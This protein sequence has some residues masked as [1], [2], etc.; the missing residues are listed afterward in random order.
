MFE[1]L[2]ASPV[3]RSGRPFAFAL[4]LHSL[5]VVTA[6]ELRPAT[7]PPARVARL[8]PAWIEPTSTREPS[9][10]SG[11]PRAGASDR[12]MLPPMPSVNVDIGPVGRLEVPG[13]LLS[14]WHPDVPGTDGSVDIVAG[15]LGDAVR[16]L[17]ER[18]VPPELLEPDVIT[19]DLGR[20]GLSGAATLQC[21]VDREGRVISSSISVIDSTGP[22]VAAAARATLRRVRYRPGRIAGE[23]VPIEIRQRFTFDAR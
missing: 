5:I 12:R 22:E 6:V 15:I 8:I 1:L 18:S 19:R 10:A 16:H 23:P 14:A 20:L 21:V 7:A 3:R 13:P 11:S 4:L 17:E 2:A 9:D